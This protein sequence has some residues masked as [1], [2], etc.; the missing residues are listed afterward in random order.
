MKEILRRSVCL[1][2]LLLPVMLVAQQQPRVLVVYFS[3]TGQTEAMAEAVLRG[4]RSVH[5]VTAELRTVAAATNADLLAADAI[6]LGSPVIN[7]NVAPE[8]ASFLRD[9]PFSGMPLANKLGAAFATGGG[10]SAGEE[11]VQLNILHSMLIFG[12]IVVGG[13]DWTS[14]FGASAVTGET[15]F[16]SSTSAK[17]IADSFLAKG[18]KLGKRVAELCLKLHRVR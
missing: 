1:T 2:L 17:P 18:E 13:P 12:M 14:P 7:A 3:Q 5:G 6:I 10:I 16:D 8:V 4:A 15:P 9:W 11:L